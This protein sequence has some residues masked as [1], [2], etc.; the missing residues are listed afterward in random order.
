[1]I[2]L[3]AP[4]SSVVA[5]AIGVKLTATAG[6]LAVGGGLGWIAALSTV[7]STYEEVVPGMLLIGL[8]AGLLLPTATNTVLGSVPKGDS[9]VGS[10]TNTVALQVGGALGVAVVGS[11]MSTH[12]QDHLTTSLAGRHVPAGILQTILGSLGG[13]LAVA[14]RVGG[15]TGAQLAHAARAAFMSGS[16]VGMAVGAA[17][18]LC[19]A[20]VTLVALPSQVASRP[21]DPDVVVQSDLDPSH[22]SIE[23]SNPDEAARQS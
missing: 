22:S 13:A 7:T 12:Y 4:L 23:Q 9:G 14:E 10:A 5:R 16:K 8:G 21:K 3:V 20:V 15:A 19:G 18:A 17:V 6:L 1:V 2:C 11:I